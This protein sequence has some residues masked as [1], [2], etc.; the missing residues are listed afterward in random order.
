VVAAL[1]GA[2]QA[3]PVVDVTIPQAEVEAAFQS[4]V[5]Q[6][7]EPIGLAVLANNP[8]L[9]LLKGDLVRA[10]NG[11]ITLSPISM[12]F[13]GNPPLVYLDVLR[14]G[15]PVVVRI[16]VT[17]VAIEEHVDRDRYKETLD[18][19]QNLGPHMFKQVTKNGSPS[20]L[21][22]E[23]YFPPLSDGDI[24]RKIDG[25]AVPGPTEAMTV[26]AQTGDHKDVN[27][28]IERL[29]KTLV[30]KVIID[31]SVSLD[32]ALVARIVK[33]SDTAYEIPRDVVDAILSN[34]MALAQGARVVPAVKDGKPN[35]F[36]LYAIR[37]SSVFAA[38]GLTN[39]DT[40]K[41]INGVELSSADKALE[42]YTKLRDAKKLTIEIERRGAA[43]TL[44]YTIKN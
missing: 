30:A 35:G 33:K 18:M 22:V 34:P 25:V 21:V 44:T 19:L 17:R 40:L 31:T 20:G 2:A 26:L 39:G 28:E 15:K 8:K 10:V 27:F 12:S 13:R 1:A 14:G 37:P 4:L 7:D 43:I 5:P 24:I 23:G 42:A 11:E 36:K 6:Y 3:G 38:L 9:G 32:P 41:K 16:V 29:G